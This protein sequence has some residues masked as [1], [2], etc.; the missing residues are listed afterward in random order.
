M[1]ASHSKYMS[2][3]GAVAHEATSSCNLETFAVSSALPGADVTRRF[4]LFRPWVAGLLLM[5]IQLVVAVFLLAPDGSFSFRY[6]SLVQHDGYWFVNIIDRGYQTTVPPINHKVME[7]SNV[8]F[9]PA[10]PALASLIRSIFGIESETALPIAAQLA[11]WG[12]WT[13]FF[14]LCERWKLSPTLRLFGTLAIVAHPAA[15]FLIAGYSESLFL[16]ALLGFI[17]WTG[18]EGRAAKILAALHGIIMSAT[19]IVGVP[20][21]AYPVVRDFFKKGWTVLRE[22]RSWIR[23]YGASILTMSV[24]ILGAAAF[25]IYCQVRWGR[26][27]MYMLTQGA[28]WNIEPD[29]FAVFRPSSY[30]WLMPQL[31]DPTQMSQMSMTVGALL[32][33][34]IAIVELIPAITRRT[35][36]QTRIG[37]YFCAAVIYYI[38]VAGVASLD[39]ESMLRYGF[40]AHALI[41]LAFLHFLRQ[42]RVSPPLL[43]TLGIATAVLIIA[44]GLSVQGWYV[45]NF[46]RG[47][48]VA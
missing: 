46:T 1:S 44:L 9:F 2:V 25:F 10:Y 8:A 40:C 23:N 4:S 19:R 38:S 41:V 33:V 18:A 17:Y 28:G 7:V 13:Y 45:W 31:N 26:W 32:L 20:C 12:F 47:N 6:Q 42:F 22:P 24:A 5:L 48:W 37:I 36:W 14:L 39:M 34:V 21:A 16:M 43:R 30:R 29:Y 11:A 35:D 15:F 27:D 3:P